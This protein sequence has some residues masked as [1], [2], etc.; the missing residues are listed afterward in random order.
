MDWDSYHGH[1]DLNEF[2]DELAATYSWVETVSIGQ[3]YEGR[4][5][6]VIQ[7]NKAGP[8]A[9]TVWVESGIHAREWISPAVATFM[10]R[11][12]VERYDDNPTYADNI[13]FHFLPSANPDGYEYSRSDVSF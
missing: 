2:I 10:I 11:Q 12:I 1:D 5:M 7:I 8:G 3:S 6:R 9:P 4:D 13:N